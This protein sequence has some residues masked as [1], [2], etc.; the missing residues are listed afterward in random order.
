MKRGPPVLLA[1]VLVGALLGVL[2][3]KLGG[4]ADAELL[5]RALTEAPHGGGA[6]THLARGG[7]RRHA[8]E[9]RAR[10]VGLALGEPALAEVPLR[11]VR[12]RG[13][14]AAS[15][16][17]PITGSVHERAAPRRGN[18]VCTRATRVQTSVHCSRHFCRG[19][20]DGRLS[21]DN[22]QTGRSSRPQCT[23]VWGMGRERGARGLRR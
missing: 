20:L 5:V 12:R 4:A 1:R 19:R 22:A 9:R 14:H 16:P 2:S 18:A 8:G 10:R 23:E 3:D 13:N 6:D 11:L 21:R 15:S 17:Q 7:R